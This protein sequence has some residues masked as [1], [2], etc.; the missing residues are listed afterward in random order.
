MQQEE[1]LVLKPKK[2][3]ESLVVEES[4]VIVKPAKTKMK[5]M[6]S[7]ANLITKGLLKEAN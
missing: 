4:P 5:K 6:R 1:D 7:S 3:D 2:R